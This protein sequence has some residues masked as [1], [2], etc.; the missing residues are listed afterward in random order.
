LVR[1]GS[2]VFDLMT[3]DEHLALAAARASKLSRRKATPESAY[4]AIPL[5][6]GLRRRQAGLLSGGQR[7]AL[8]LGMSV[9]L[10]PQIL[11]LD[12]P[13]TGLAPTVV[14]QIYSIIVDLSERG[15][16]LLIAEQNPQWLVEICHDSYI[17]DVGRLTPG[18]PRGAENEERHH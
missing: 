2:R 8:G 10:S 5:L 9:V 3:V 7:Q 12:E 6:D 17:M 18:T 14:E 15:T 1:E 4:D 11:L 16:T 13:S